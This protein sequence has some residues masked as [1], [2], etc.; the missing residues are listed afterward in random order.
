MSTNAQQQLAQLLKE[1]WT[2]HQPA[3][4]HQLRLLSGI[5]GERLTL[6]RVD[7]RNL[8]VTATPI[9]PITPAQFDPATEFS[10]STSASTLT[11]TAPAHDQLPLLP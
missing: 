7:L 1:V 5:T 8:T 4:L 10:P 3:P 6:V 9:D 11:S 2:P